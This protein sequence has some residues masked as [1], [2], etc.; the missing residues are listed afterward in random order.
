MKKRFKASKTTSNNVKFVIAL[1]TLAVTASVLAVLPGLRAAG[2]G[3]LTLSP[4]SG[5]YTTGNSFTVTVYEDS[6][7][8]TI[9]TVQADLQYDASKLQFVSI[10]ANQPTSAFGVKAAA[11][12]GSGSVTFQMGNIQALSG[13]QPVGTVTFKVLGSSGSTAVNFKSSS[14][15]LTNQSPATD[16]WNGSTAGGSYTL[17]APAT[18]TPST[19]S[20]PASPSKPSTSTSKP[21]TSTKPTTSSNISPTV[22]QQRADP[23]QPVPASQ[24]SNDN[25]LYFVAI[26]VVDDKGKLVEGAEVT[27]GKNK[28]K[29]D[30]TGT[31]SFSDIAA[32]SYKV[33][34]SS[35]TV[36][37]SSTINVAS[38]LPTASVQE[39][40]VKTGPKYNWALFTKIGL[41]ILALI[42]VIAFLKS[43]I[44]GKISGSLSNRRPG[45][46]GSSSNTSAD[47]GISGPVTTTISPG[48]SVTNTA[49]PTP[50]ASTSAQ[51]KANEDNLV[52]PKVISPTPKV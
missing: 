4:S 18:S 32:G 11:N 37:G 38:G 21:S 5:T 9:N 42:L 6:G 44:I 13:K 41:A 8:E 46:T 36:K 7:S 34:V 40:E 52:K 27:L 14:T 20:T 22:E 25:G 43:G 19:P 30:A 35:G 15:I 24:V 23:S 48:G 16:V 1:V 29:T 26:K 50:S 17:K 12:G 39:F 51:V 33:S 45:P 3:T 47:S 28:A 49:T 2:T 10:N 31:A